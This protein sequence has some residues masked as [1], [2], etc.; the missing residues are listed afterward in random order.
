[1]ILLGKYK[2]KKR[3]SKKIMKNNFVKQSIS[4][5]F[6]AQIIKYHKKSQN[7]HNLSS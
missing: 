1:M 5:K 4:T 3:V 2:D 6:A 7:E